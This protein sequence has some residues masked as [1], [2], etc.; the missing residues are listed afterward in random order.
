[1]IASCTPLDVG[2]AS[3][4]LHH[5]PPPWKVEI[6]PPADDEPPVPWITYGPAKDRLPARFGAVIEYAERPLRVRI[7]ATF[8]GAE[9]VKAQVVAV[10]RTDGQSV[11]PEDMTA[12]QLG[13]V[14]DA[15]VWEA[16]EHHGVLGQG[17]RGRTGPPTDEELLTLAQIYWR[18]YIAW[19]K[20]RQAVMSTFELPRSTAN[21][22]IRKAREKYG[23]PGMHAS[24]E[25]VADGGQHRQ[26]T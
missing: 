11:T 6:E 9:R 8:D 14:M 1:M 13:A 3:A 15:V 18:E 23:L 24:D 20:P 16:T 4:Y 25:E 19:R 17:G 5:V 7:A 22:W 26:A 2:S 10:E 21:A 12:T